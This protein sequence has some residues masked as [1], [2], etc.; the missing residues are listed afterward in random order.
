MAV[1]ALQ[2][3]GNPDD[4]KSPLQQRGDISNGQS[5]G[6]ADRNG[7]NHDIR[8]NEKGP[9]DRREKRLHVYLRSFG[10]A[11]PAAALSMGLIVNA[12]NTFKCTVQKMNRQSLY[13]NHIAEY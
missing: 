1:Q 2:Q 5:K 4:E 9:L 7:N 6:K 11:P 12:Y 3:G 13:H 8:Q 10:K